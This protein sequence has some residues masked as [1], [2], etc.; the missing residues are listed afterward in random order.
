MKSAPAITF[1]YAPSRWL[2]AALTL[3]ALLAALAIAASAI[4]TWMKLL[5]AAAAGIYA[6]Y[7]LRRLLR[8][9]VRHCA[10]YESGH[11]RVRDAGGQDHAA[12]LLSASVRGSLIVLRLRS[13]LQ[14][15]SALK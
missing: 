13:E 8:P 9:I 7:A 12:S 3:V 5:L 14:R 4:Q 15:S 6:A 10:W 11:W 2:V 1:D